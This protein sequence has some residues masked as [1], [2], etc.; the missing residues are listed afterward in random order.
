MS[1]FIWQ[2]YPDAYRAVREDDRD[3]VALVRYPNARAYL[4]MKDESLWG[5]ESDFTESFPSVFEW[6]IMTVEN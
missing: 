4:K 2:S 3:M 5:C 1:W 6:L